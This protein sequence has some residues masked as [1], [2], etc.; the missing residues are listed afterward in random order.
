MEDCEFINEPIVIFISAVENYFLYLLPAASL[1]TT[2][3]PAITA[4]TKSPSNGDHGNYPHLS[5]QRVG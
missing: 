4:A 1:K 3:E 2:V 5:P